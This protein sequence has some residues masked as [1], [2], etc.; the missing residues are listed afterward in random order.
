[1]SEN[2]L[3]FVSIAS[4]RDPQLLPT[5]L[6]CL[7]KASAPERLRFGVCWQRA[8]EDKALPLWED[9]RFRVMD[10]D[11][12][13][14]K[15]A[16]W[17]RAEVMNLWRGEDWFLQVDSHCRF[18][19]GWDE[20][21]VRMAEGTE[22]AKPILSTYATPFTPV[23]DDSGE[24]EVLRGGPLQMVF[25]GFTPEGI[26]QLRPGA[27]P[28][29]WKGPG[30]MRGRFVSAGFL[31]APG[32][33]VEEVPYDPELYFMGE[34]SAL[35]VRAFTHGYD[36]FHPAET[37]VWHDYIRANAK[38]HWGDH[39]DA[40]VVATP[41]G[42]LDERSKRKVQRILL[43]EQVGE[44]GLGSERTLAE[45]EA[46]AGLS[47][48]LRKAQQYTVRGGEVPNPAVDL[49]WAE[50][51]YPWIA[52]VRVQRAEL[53]VGALNDPML[54]SVAVL[55]EEGFELYRRDLMAEE[56]KPMVG[57]DGEIALIFEFD[58]QTVPAGWTIMPLTR[59]GG[60]LPMVKGR[61]GDGDFAVLKADE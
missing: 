17:A 42:E 8:V 56:L 21:L 13:Q 10:V 61:L 5:L 16:C 55:D 60:W 11:W 23:A 19:Q 7:R 4:Y 6:D 43:G 15:G 59:A 53:P 2:D 40:E 48:R 51:I 46:Y 3:I 24:D 22:S 49:D 29:G 36:F 39:T 44:F 54:W 1:L 32:R 18:A 33:F 28:T 30:A 20:T 35:T 50:R 58:S 52:R 26:P 57:S 47:F 9:P 25:Q 45:Y 34:E 27:F 31:F 38:K 12:R 41:W 14:S 37:V